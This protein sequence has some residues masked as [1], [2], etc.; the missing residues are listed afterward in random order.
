MAPVIDT[1]SADG[2]LALP[3]LRKCELLA[4]PRCSYYRLRRPAEPDSE[5]QELIDALHRLCED[6]PCY[7]Y[8]RICVEVRKT[9][10]GV[11]HKRVLRLMRQHGLLV[12]PRRRFVPTTDSNHR[13]RIYEN[14]IKHRRLTGINQVWVSDI[15]YIAYG[16]LFA[17]LAVVL[18]AYSRKVVGW[19]VS[20]HV[21]TAL[22]LGALE[23]ALQTRELPDGLIHHSDRGVQYASQA[24]VQRLLEHD[25]AISMSAPG[26]PYENA[27]AESFMKTIKTEE[28]YRN[29]Y[30]SFEEVEASI[31]YYIEEIYNTRRLHSAIGYTS[32]TL[33]EQKLTNS[34][35]YQPTIGSTVNAVSL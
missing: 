8:R 26:N 27:K 30:D 24:Y 16:T 32:P 22:T 18:D 2:P 7:G 12:L 1:P 15:T 29:E 31:G 21:D 23:M 4:I 17:Y 14:L 35:P 34:L 5:E 19:K 9:I 6:N 28:V 25:I 20:R 13:L 11:N 3:A 33:F 10:P